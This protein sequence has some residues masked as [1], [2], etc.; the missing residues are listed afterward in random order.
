M[1]RPCGQR[2]L[3][4][5]VTLLLEKLHD[6]DGAAEVLRQL[7]KLKPD[8]DQVATQL[9][10]ALARSGK[11]E[12]EMALLRERV[13]LAPPARRAELLV[14]LAQREADFGDVAGA[15]KSLE[16]ALV[17]RPDERARWPSWRASARGWIRLGGLR[18]SR[19]SARRRWR[20]LPEAVVRSSTRREFISIGSRTTRAPG[21]VWSAG[22]VLDARS[23]SRTPALLQNL[24]A[25][26]APTSRRAAS[27][28]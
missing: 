18:C 20:P 10:A 23:T 2:L 1:G 16:K 9:G 12:E 15:Q 22:Q 8:D 11:R 7:R 14:E 4:R 13:S 24:H 3:Q 28:S 5:R 25:P 6:D 27:W 17:E 26:T 19:G 21:A